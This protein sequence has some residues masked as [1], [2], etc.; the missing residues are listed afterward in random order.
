M[1]STSLQRYD[2]WIDPSDLDRRVTRRFAH[3][4]LGMVFVI[5]ISFLIWADQAVLDEVTRGEGRVVPSGQT[6]VIQ[7]LEGG[8]LAEVLTSEGQIVEKGQ[9]LMRI[10]NT[11]AESRLRELKQRY[12]SGLSTVAR[13]EAEIAGVTDPEAIKF[14]DDLLQGAPDVARSELALFTIRQQ[15]L[16][17]QLAILQDQLSQRQQELAELRGKADNLRS[18]FGLAQKE[19]DITQPLAAQGVVSKVDLLRLERQVNDLRSDINAAD[20]ARPRAEAAV[21]EARKRLNERVVTFKTDAS[22]DLTKAKLELA[23]TAEEMGANQDRVTRTEVRSPVHGTIKEIK[24]RTIGGVI[25]PGQN[26]VEVVPIEDTLLVEAQIRPSDIAFIRP[27]QA[28]VVKV[29]AYDF[30]TYGGLDAVVEE[31]SA[32]TIQN[33]KGEHFFRIRLRTDKN[34]LGTTEKPLPIIP[35]M[36]ASVDI[37]TGH[38]TVLEYLLA[39]VMRARDTALR[40]R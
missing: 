40:E 32:D 11:V 21:E 15:Q 36:T 35:G 30:S 4:L 29:T 16:Q 19:L 12:F 2:D 33:E 37:L 1:A 18:S 17:S 25:Q 6:Q 13:L 9:V 20:L 24:I 26:L 38:K 31:I 27:K 3:I 39:P 28:A 23:A 8:I 34:F 7:N 22:Q 5:V 14:P 10:D